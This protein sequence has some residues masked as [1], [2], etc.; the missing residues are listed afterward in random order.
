MD[1][2][3]VNSMSVATIGWT[4]NIATRV[5][6]KAPMTIPTTQLARKAASMVIQVIPPAP[7][8]IWTNTLEVIAA[9]TPTLMS[10][11]PEDEVTRVM[12]IARITSSEAPNRMFGMFPYS[13][14]LM[15]RC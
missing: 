2:P 9:A 11:P 14:P 10:W 8:S 13:A 6:L 3:A 1:L 4:L 7:R 5:P 12:P 15:T